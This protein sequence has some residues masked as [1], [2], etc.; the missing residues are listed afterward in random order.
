MIY[1]ENH[2]K[3]GHEKLNTLIKIANVFNEHDILWNLGSSCMLYLKNVVDHFDDIDLMIAEKDMDK[4][5]LLMDGLGEKKE[6][7]ENNIYATKTF[8]HYRVDDVDVDLMA[9]FVIVFQEEN[10]YFPLITNEGLEQIHLGGAL[11][12]LESIDTWL[13]YYTL[14]NRTDKV[15]IIEKYINERRIG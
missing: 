1:N 2:H 3:M 11:I 10:Y 7:K 14:M 12:Y 6:K 15:D 5:M 4:A 8:V 9:G 13:H